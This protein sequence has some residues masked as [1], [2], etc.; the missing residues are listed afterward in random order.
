MTYLVLL[1]R[2]FVVVSDFVLLCGHEVALS[3]HL[4]KLLLQL[5]LVSIGCTDPRLQVDE[6]LDGIGL[7]H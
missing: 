5:E 2:D 3:A 1:R 7:F 6:V 4:Q